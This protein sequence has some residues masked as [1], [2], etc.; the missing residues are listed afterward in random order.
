MR[1]LGARVRVDG[2]FGSSG[3]TGARGDSESDGRTL[4]G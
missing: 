2:G 4:I 3:R 1:L